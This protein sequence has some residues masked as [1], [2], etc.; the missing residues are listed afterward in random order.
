LG[1]LEFFK[2]VGVD[3]GAVSGPGEI[4]LAPDAMYKEVRGLKSGSALVE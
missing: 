2:R 4:G 3:H 1:D